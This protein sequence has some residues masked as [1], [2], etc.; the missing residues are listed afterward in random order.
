MVRWLIGLFTVTGLWC[1]PL[2]PAFANIYYSGH[3]MEVARQNYLI[4]ITSGNLKESNKKIIK[5]KSAPQA[6]RPNATAYGWTLK[7]L[8]QHKGI[9]RRQTKYGLLECYNEDGPFRCT[10]K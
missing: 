10:W 1:F 2:S 8:P 7:M 5:L 4:V 9:V 3:G 6:T